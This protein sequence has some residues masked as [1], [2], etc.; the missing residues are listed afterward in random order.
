MHS[1]P[2]QVPLVF[3]GLLAL[4]VPG[5]V[6]CGSTALIE[7]RCTRCADRGSRAG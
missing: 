5:I 7:R 2:S 3:A 4:A 6:L 1:Q